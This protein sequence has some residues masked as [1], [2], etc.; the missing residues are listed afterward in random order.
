MCIR[1]RINSWQ[2]NDPTRQGLNEQSRLLL[3]VIFDGIVGSVLGL[4]LSEVDDSNGQTLDQLMQL[5]LDLRS[6]ARAH[7]DWTTSD[8]IR[9]RLDEINIQVKDG[10]EGAT[11]GFK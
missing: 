8:K 10:K 9:D 7:K 4:Q 11:W 2:H 1:D 3:A 5:V 6:D